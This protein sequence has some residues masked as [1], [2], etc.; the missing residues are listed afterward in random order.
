MLQKTEAD[1]D[2]KKDK[3]LP[4]NVASLFDHG[5]FTYKL[6]FEAET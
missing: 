1:G 5:K 4:N 2:L 3:S 6:M